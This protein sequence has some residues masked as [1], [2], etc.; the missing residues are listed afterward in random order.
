MTAPDDMIPVIGFHRG[1]GLHDQQTPERLR[2]VCREID[3]ILDD[4]N[5]VHELVEWAGAPRNSPESRLLAEAKVMAMYSS[6]ADARESRPPIDILRLRAT[7]AGVNSRQWR[8]PRIYGSTLDERRGPANEDRG[9][10]RRE[11]PLED[12]RPKITYPPK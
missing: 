1:I 4:V 6:A 9:G 5:D 7:T 2:L 11:V 8:S 12:T 10:V 3:H